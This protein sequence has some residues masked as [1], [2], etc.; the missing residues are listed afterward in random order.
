M[1]EMNRQG[2]R[3]PLTGAPELPGGRPTGRP[4]LP[5]RPI[6]VLS[7]PYIS[8]FKRLFLPNEFNLSSCPQAL[9]ALVLFPLAV[10]TSAPPYGGL[11]ALESRRAEKA[12]D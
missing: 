3:D 2:K 7:F 10:I 5:S 12:C 9:Y 1:G 6:R 11:C 4:C 8:E